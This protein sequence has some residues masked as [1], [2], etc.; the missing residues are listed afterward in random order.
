[1]ETDNWPDEAI[2]EKKRTRKGSLEWLSR[3]VKLAQRSYYRAVCRGL[4]TQ[5]SKAW[6]DKLVSKSIIAQRPIIPFVVADEL[7]GADLDID[8]NPQDVKS[9]IWKYHT[10]GETKFLTGD[11]FSL[12]GSW[13]LTPVEEH[14]TYRA[15]RELVVSSGDFTRTNSYL[16]ALQ[17]LAEHGP[18]FHNGRYVETSEDLNSYF[19]KYSKLIESIKR[20]GFARN[21]SENGATER[22]GLAIDHVGN[23]VHFQKGNHRFAILREL[24]FKSIPVR[25]RLLHNDWLRDNWQGNL[26]S[27]KSLV[28]SIR[29]QCRT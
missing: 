20:E 26:D 14:W 7:L 12:Q 10:I 18:H 27:Q 29:E 5:M 17:R 13:Q 8:I 4:P 11:W 28:Q 3:R 24:G 6:L 2:L 9:R 25:L 15:M 23:L 16:K 21:H 1:M 22:I 19:V